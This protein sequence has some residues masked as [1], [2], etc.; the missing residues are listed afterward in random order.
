M[1][2]NICGIVINAL[3]KLTEDGH[4]DK[5]K[6]K[7]KFSRARINGL[8]PKDLSITF[9]DNNTLIFLDLIFYKNISETPELTALEKDLNA[10]FPNARILIIAIND[11]VNFTGYSL[12]ENGV[13]LRTKAL[14]NDAIFLDFGDLNEKEKSLYGEILVSVMK[15]S[16]TLKKIEAKTMNYS[17]IDK[18]K[19]YLKYRDVIYR[20][21]G[22]ENNFNY[23]DGS[24]DNFIIENEFRKLLN[25]DYY[26]VENMEFIVFERRKLNFAKD[27][28]KEYLYLAKKE[29]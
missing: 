24:L 28:L 15:H 1:G 25:R 10:I 17:A 5:K 27:S 18:K 26:E 29:F 21:A 8:S 12:I 2:N 4:Y 13:K 19:F 22:A 3:P 7:T 11:T 6:L 9:S 23:T 16:E 14:V 20:N